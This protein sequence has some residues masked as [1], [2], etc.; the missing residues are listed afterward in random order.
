MSRG[1]CAGTP[2]SRLGNTTGNMATVVAN[3]KTEHDLISEA[4]REGTYVPIHRPSV[5]GNPFVIGPDGTRQEVIAKYE[6]YVR[7]TPSLLAKL[8]RLDGKVL[9]CFCAPLPCHGDVLIKLIAERREE[10]KTP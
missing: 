1:G 10:A 9:G 6:A 8:P 3:V 2:P 7:R 5:W 4:K